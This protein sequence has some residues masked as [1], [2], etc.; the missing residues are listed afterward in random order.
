MI[1]KHDHAARAEEFRC[2][3]IVKNLIAD[4]YNDATMVFLAAAG[5]SFVVQPL[6]WIGADIP[7]WLVVG[8]A[9]G[10]F[11]VALRR[12]VQAGLFSRRILKTVDQDL[13]RELAEKRKVGNR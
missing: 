1:D 10:V 11:T 9:L 7:V 8:C 2:I 5:V 13:L 6:S 12:F 4:K 3:A